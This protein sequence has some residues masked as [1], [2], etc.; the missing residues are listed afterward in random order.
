[1]N[2]CII[3]VSTI[4]PLS[5]E[6]RMKPEWKVGEEKDRM[7]RKFSDWGKG[8]GHGRCFLKMLSQQN[9]KDFVQTDQLTKCQIRISANNVDRKSCGFYGGL[10]KDDEGSGVD[11]KRNIILY[12]KGPDFVF[13]RALLPEPV[14]PRWTLDTKTDRSLLPISISHADKEF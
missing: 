3:W 12:S 14:H 2:V 1:M 7:K 13:F 6:N 4:F 5:S 9:G 10:W 11:S 8:N